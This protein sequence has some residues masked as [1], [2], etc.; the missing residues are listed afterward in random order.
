MGAPPERQPVAQHK[1]GP[2]E[3]VI[4]GTLTARRHSTGTS[5]DSAR[6]ARR[7]PRS[8]ALRSDVT[9]WRAPSLDNLIR[10]VIPAVAGPAKLVPLEARWRRKTSASWLCETPPSADGCWYVAEQ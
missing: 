1:R 9:F 4:H 2:G 8:A 5:L 6:V 3:R 10:F 7:V